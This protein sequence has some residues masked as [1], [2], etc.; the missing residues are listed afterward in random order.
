MRWGNYDTKSNAVRFVSAEV[1]SSITNFANPVPGSQT[2]P[3]S[4]YL[5]SRPS[6][7]GSVAWPPFGPDVT[8][9][10]LAGYGGHANKIPA[11]LCY[12]AFGGPSNGGGSP[13]SFNADTCYGGGDP[14]PDPP[15]GLEATPH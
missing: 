13:L 12:E 5:T 3:A 14:P 11:Q 6:W 7:F 2:L 10:N 15:Q 4:F 1:P 9:G 8:G